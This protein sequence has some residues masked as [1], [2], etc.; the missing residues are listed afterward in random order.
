MLGTALSNPFQA[1][2]WPLPKPGLLAE[3]FLASACLDENGNPAIRL[4]W[5]LDF[6]KS[7]R[8]A[9]WVISRDDFGSG[10]VG[11]T[12]GST[13]D[14]L[15][16][17]SSR[18]VKYFKNSSTIRNPICEDLIEAETE[19]VGIL[20]G[21]PHA[22]FVSAI[23]GVS[24]LDMPPGTIGL[25][26][27]GLSKFCYFRSDQVT[28]TSATALRRPNH[29]FPPLNAKV[30]DFSDFRF[31]SVGTYGFPI[32]VGYVLQISKSEDFMRGVFTSAELVSTAIRDTSIT[33]SPR[34]PGD[35]FIQFLDDTVGAKIGAQDTRLWWRI[36][37]RNV[38]DVPGP[39]R[40]K[41]TGLRYIFSEA[42][43]FNRP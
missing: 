32:Y 20:V 2:T 42:R 31:T 30:S 37:A 5:K 41:A 35:S 22:Y 27:E 43:S 18:K 1:G 21:R 13:F 10:P 15:D 29:V 19:A 33:L 4:T 40:D 34:F 9:L 28:S 16:T 39:V 3:H 6:F 24:S 14:F 8:K 12:D 17:S 11:A 36:G 38:E 23:Y 7:Y 25:P 26:K